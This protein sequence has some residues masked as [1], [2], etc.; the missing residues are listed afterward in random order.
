M[1][2]ITKKTNSQFDK[3]SWVLRAVS[4]DQTR[5]IL[6]RAVYDDGYL[7]ATDG[8]RLN[9]AKIEPEWLGLTAGCELTQFRVIENK[10][11]RIILDPINDGLAFPN[12]K[13]V[14]ASDL[15]PIEFLRVNKYGVNTTFT[16]LKGAGHVIGKDKQAAS[17]VFARIVSACAEPT[18]FRFEYLEQ[19]LPPTDFKAHQTNAAAPVIFWNDDYLSVITPIRFS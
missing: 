7:V 4:M 10:R 15:V 11:S 14:I 13:A 17:I 16:K 19:G 8:R 18:C 6:M 12:Y 2:E 5:E 3:V 9:R 1:I